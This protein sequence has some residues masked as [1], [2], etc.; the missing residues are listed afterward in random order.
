MNTLKLQ[1]FILFKDLGKGFLESNIVIFVL[2]IEIHFQL[3]D[4]FVIFLTNRP[5]NIKKHAE[6]SAC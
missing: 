1:T 6:K 3:L 2:L 4:L 5:L